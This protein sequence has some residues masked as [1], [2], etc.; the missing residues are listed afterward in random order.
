MWDCGLLVE[1]QVGFFLYP[2]L[3]RQSSTLCI[4]IGQRRPAFSPVISYQFTLRSSYSLLANPGPAEARLTVPGSPDQITLQQHTG[5]SG[6]FP[7]CCTSSSRADEFHHPG[8]DILKEILL[9]YVEAAMN[10]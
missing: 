1:N 2:P 10:R 3:F 8:A 7:T 6:G 5:T 4:G 9:T